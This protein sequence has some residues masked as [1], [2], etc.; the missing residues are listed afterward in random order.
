MPSS[1]NI[2]LSCRLPC[3]HADSISEE[4]NR[5]CCLNQQQS[6]HPYVVFMRMAFCAASFSSVVLACA[7]TSITARGSTKRRMCACVAKK[8]VRA[9]GEKAV[10]APWACRAAH[11]RAADP[12][13]SFHVHVH[14][15]SYRSNSCCEYAIRLPVPPVPVPVPVPVLKEFNV[16]TRVLYGTVS[17]CCT[18][19]LPPWKKEGASPAPR[20]DGKA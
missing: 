9:L 15:G 1:S 14:V 10:R 18:A 16:C 8:A 17:T 13:D 7:H 11:P 4:M 12:R 20:M 2:S 6:G 19:E 3:V 5:G